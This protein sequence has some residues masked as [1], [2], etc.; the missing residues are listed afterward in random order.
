MAQKVYAVT[1]TRPREARWE[2]SEEEA[3]S[4]NEKI[5]KA[6]EEAGG[7]TLARLGT[8]SSEWRFIFV[9]VFPVLRHTISFIKLFFPRRGCML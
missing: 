4:L 9:D 2:L 3:K 5:Q 7:K 6:V 1:R 8:W